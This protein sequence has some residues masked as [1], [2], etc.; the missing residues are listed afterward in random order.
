MFHSHCKQTHHP[1]GGWPQLDLCGHPEH[2]GL[3]F[4]SC[5]LSWRFCAAVSVAMTNDAVPWSLCVVQLINQSLK[6]YNS[7]AA[8]PSRT[9]ENR[10]VSTVSQLLGVRLGLIVQCPRRTNAIQSK[11]MPSTSRHTSGLLTK[12]TPE[13][14]APQKQLL[15]GFWVRGAWHKVTLFHTDGWSLLSR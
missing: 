10:C 5:M 11:A 15:G 14:Q 7:P 2:S 12:Q 6:R 8:D 3:G 4:P 13:S 9:R 1:E